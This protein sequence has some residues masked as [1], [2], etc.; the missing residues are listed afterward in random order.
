MRKLRKPTTAPRE[1]SNK[2]HCRH[3]FWVGNPQARPGRDF[4]I[5]SLT[6]ARRKI[7]SVRWPRAIGQ[8]D[9]SARLK[10]IQSF[11][12]KDVITGKTIKLGADQ[13]PDCGVVTGKMRT[14]VSPA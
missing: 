6:L 10:T 11:V 5:C 12:I 9:A 4:S 7:R 13:H 3:L 14:I 1:K 8:A 2:G